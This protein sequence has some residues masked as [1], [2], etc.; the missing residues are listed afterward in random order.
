[1]TATTPFQIQKDRIRARLN[2]YTVRAFRMLPPVDKPRILDVGCGSGISTL[3]VA[4]LCNGT[5]TALDIDESVLN[6][7]TERFNKAGLSDRVETRH[8]SLLDMDFPEASF[9]I[10]LAE[11]SISVIGFQRGLREWKRFLK[12]EGFMVIH[13]AQGNIPRKL[14]QIAECGCELLGYFTLG[15]D[16]WSAEYFAPLEELIRETRASHADDPLIREELQSAQW[17]VDTFRKDPENN[18]SVC[19][20]MQKK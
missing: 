18:S 11:G 14:E 10:I 9:D 8:G 19:F 6:Q 16:V 17:E 4:G 3:E 12:P 2:K 15:Q 13:D 20:V 7:L 1:M 5:I